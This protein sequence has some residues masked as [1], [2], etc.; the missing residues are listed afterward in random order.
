MGAVSPVP[1]A[2]DAFMKKVIDRVVKPTMKGIH[3]E[4][5][6]Y[7]GFIFFGLI[8]VNGDPFVIEYNCRMGDPETEVVMPRIA[9]DIL[10]L[11][12]AAAAGTLAG[13]SLEKDVRAASTVML[14]AGGYPEEYEKGDA[15]AGL[16]EVKDSMVFHAGTAETNGNIVTNGGRVLAI[17]SYGNDIHDALRVSYEN[18][19][20]I[21]WKGKYYRTDLGRDLK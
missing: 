16:D 19:E 10:P 4:G 20:K 8:N 13:M 17:T 7:T 3:T 11:L 5:M 1:F 14:V 21:N 6:R 9:G 2:D 15:I 18:A 12:H